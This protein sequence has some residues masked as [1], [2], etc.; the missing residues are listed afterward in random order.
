[1]D[2]GEGGADEG[3]Q[4]SQTW[5]LKDD[6]DIECF[7]NAGVGADEDGAFW[8]SA[9]GGSSGHDRDEPPN[10]MDGRSCAM[11][12]FMAEKL[13]YFSCPMSP[14]SSAGSSDFAGSNLLGFA[15]L[16]GSK[17]EPQEASG[18][19]SLGEF[20]DCESGGFSIEADGDG[21]AAFLVEGGPAEPRAEAAA[22]TTP[23]VDTVDLLG[24]FI[25]DHFAAG[26]VSD[27]VPAP[28]SGP[29]EAL[30]QPVVPAEAADLRDPPPTAATAERQPS[31]GPSGRGAA[32]RLPSADELDAS[33]EVV[34]AMGNLDCG[35][36]GGG[37]G[38]FPGPTGPTVDEGCTLAAAAA[39]VAVPTAA[40]A[41]VRS[42]TAPAVASQPVAAAAKAPVPAFLR[43]PRGLHV[44][45]LVCGTRGDVQPFI[46]I[47]QRLQVG[48]RRL[49]A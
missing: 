34:S 45:V 5:V 8:G 15:S 21:A 23:A 14:T 25:G 2:T 6:G 46:L 41:A 42:E 33:W 11:E 36:G 10:L 38:G 18:D 37:C 26:R 20:L 32:A 7:S 27:L 40:A 43:I 19:S 28:S 17:G 4:S 9:P 30:P 31:G 1:M 24:S 39:A 49:A 44:A 35:G 12:E 22:A 13:S 29:A 3:V 47:A 16:H 48:C